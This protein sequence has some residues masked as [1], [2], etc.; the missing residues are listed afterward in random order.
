MEK[1]LA[2]ELAEKLAQLPDTPET[3]RK[4]LILKKHLLGDEQGRIEVAEI[5]EGIFSDMFNEQDAALGERLF[6]LIKEE[7][8]LTNTKDLMDLHL[9][10]INYLKTRRLHR[11][12]VKNDPKLQSMYAAVIQRFTSTYSKLGADLGVT[13]QQRL[14]RKVVTEDESGSITTMFANVEQYE[15]DHPEEVDIWKKQKKPEK[16]QKKDLLV[17][18]K[19]SAKKKS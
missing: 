2:K 9:M 5:E 10:I 15:K 19:K 13:R 11:V 1:D 8:Q 7:F 12:D 14:V 6:N 18:S 16:K 17:S 4:A 3:R